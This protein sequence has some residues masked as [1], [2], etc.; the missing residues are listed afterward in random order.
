MALLEK[1]EP[2]QNTN[3]TSPHKPIKGDY[4]VFESNGAKFLQ[5]N[6]YGSDGRQIPG[7]ISQTIQFSEDAIKQLKEI[8]DIYFKV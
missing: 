7:K 5:I 8:I 4:F 6:T 1:L 3:R 2:M